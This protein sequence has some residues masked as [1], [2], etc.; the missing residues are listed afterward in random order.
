M[1]IETKVL[2]KEFYNV[3]SLPSYQTSGAVAM[4][5]VCTEDVEISPGEVV[6]IHTGLAIWIASGTQTPV[7]GLILPRSSLGTKGLVLANTIGVIDGDYQGELIVQAWNRLSPSHFV[8]QWHSFEANK[9]KLQAGDRFAQLMF[10][11]V[12]KP[13]CRVVD[14]FS[15]TT[16]RGTGAFGSTGRG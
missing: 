7:V 2:N 6:A 16:E 11:P 15:N 13:E 14:D 4:D 10:V 9:I 1:K 3:E 8:S 12:I 5:L